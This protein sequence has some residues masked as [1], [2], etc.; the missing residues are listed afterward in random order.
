MDIWEIALGFM[1]SQV[2]LTAEELG[3]FE[4]LARE[5]RDAAALAAATGLPQDSAARLLTA[6]CALGLVV[7]RS[8]GA[9]ENA[10]EAAEML[11]RGGP[12]YIGGM[13]HHVREHL[14]P[15]WGF[16]K[17]ALY[18]Q[19]P[20]L[21]RALP[22]EPQPSDVVH[23]NGDALKAFM[24]GMHAVTYSAA[25]EFAE[26]ASELRRIRNIVDIGG[27]SGA[28]AIALAER[29]PE[30]RATVYDLEAV[31]P[32]AAGFIEAAGLDG[33]VSFQPGNF[34]EDELPAHADAYSLGFILH[35]WDELG[36]NILLR[37]IAAASRP[38][39]LLIVGEYLLD[40][41]RT[42]PLFVARQD[43]NML[44]AARGR[45][46]TA[47]EYRAWLLRHGFEIGSIYPTS[48]GK[49]FM[50]ASRLGGGEAA[51]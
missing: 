4:L 16:L 26:L 5:P 33:R 32:V 23:N 50:V 19:S 47:G 30:L 9:Y 35:D 31:A 49:H 6:L 1:D 44:V 18:E 51:E 48:T 38:G 8:G 24:E 22:D 2:L 45:E 21:K 43:L 7:R 42:G 3:V 34:W 15:A 20:Q 39:S 10:P 11:V 29:H 37:K 46:R 12:R 14:Y 13:F 36:G 17:E 28:F 27:A 40:E 41:S 25:A